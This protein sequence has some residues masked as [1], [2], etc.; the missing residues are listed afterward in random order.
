[1]KPYILPSNQEIKNPASIIWLGKQASSE[2]FP[3]PKRKQISQRDLKTSTFNSILSAKYECCESKSSA[4]YSKT[5]WPKKAKAHS[6]KQKQK[7]KNKQG[8]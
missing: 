3:F 1:M 8:S 7:K 4:Y 2:N 5:R 6:T